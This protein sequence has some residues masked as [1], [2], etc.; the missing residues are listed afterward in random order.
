MLFVLM[1]NK[2]KYLENLSSIVRGRG[3]TKSSIIQKKDMGKFLIGGSSSFCFRSGSLQDEYDQ[4]FVC[5]LADEQVDTVL[6]ILETDP[7]LN[8]LN[9]KQEGFVCVLPFN[10]INNL[11]F[12]N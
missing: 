12:C 5:L 11:M 4:A 9:M 2:A 8:I 3:I 6:S 1:H 7:S 10:K